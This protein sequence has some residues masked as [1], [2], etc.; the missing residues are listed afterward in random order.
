MIEARMYQP[1]HWD[2][3]NPL[4][5]TLVRHPKRDEE[6]TFECQGNPVPRSKWSLLSNQDTGSLLI[7][8]PDATWGD[9][10]TCMVGFRRVDGR[11]ETSARQHMA[12]S[13]EELIERMAMSQPSR[14]V[15][16]SND[17]RE[18]WD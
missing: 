14:P 6:I 9:C 4:I 5:V 18:A 3:H 10:C 8:M 13:P 11:I 17:G 2:E 15:P 16:I 1:R 7:Y 12:V